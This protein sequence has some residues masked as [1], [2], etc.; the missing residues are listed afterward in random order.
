MPAA[1]APLQS[2][3]SKL[4]KSRHCLHATN[5]Q[6]EAGRSECDKSRSAV[7]A[8]DAAITALE[9][10]ERRLKLSYV[11]SK[12]A[13]EKMHALKYARQQELKYARQQKVVVGKESDSLAGAYN[14]KR[15][16]WTKAHE[17]HLKAEETAKQLSVKLEA[18]EKDKDVQR[19]RAQLHRDEYTKYSAMYEAL[20]C[21]PQSPAPPLGRAQSPGAPRARARALTLTPRRHV[22]STGA[23]WT[24]SR[25][26][27]PRCDGVEWRA[28][29]L[30]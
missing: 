21:A 20:K 25:H 17:D 30:R 1:T 26:R 24:S 23:R 19:K 2:L 18:I 6:C 9:D 29:V 11:E 13:Y 10:E 4:V 14:A 22:R 3:S 16:E 28:V 8:N 15:Y 5:L 12:L 7:E 27:P